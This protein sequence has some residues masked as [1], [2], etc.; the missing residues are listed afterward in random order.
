M[1]VSESVFTDFVRRHLANEV[2]LAADQEA[3]VVFHEW[4]KKCLRKQR[5]L[6][7]TP[8][9]LGYAGPSWRV[10]EVLEELVNDC[11]MEAIFGRL[12]SIRPYLERGDR[13]EGIVRRNAL[14]FI[15]DCHR[16]NGGPGYRIF[17]NCQSA[18]MGLVVEGVLS[19]SVDKGIDNETLIST[20]HEG[21]RET[22][23]TL[24]E[25]LDV[26]SCVVVRYIV[27]VIV[28]C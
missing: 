9:F 24:R 7:Q 4:V 16:K 18:I 17:K 20:V 19:T 5:L 23:D 10:S 27:D 28:K 21:E 8:S 13:I 12:E 1:N 2:D 26:W 22:L 3:Y 11:L 15:R 25:K 14:N 6:E